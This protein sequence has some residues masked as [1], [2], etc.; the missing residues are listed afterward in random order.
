[1]MIYHIYNENNR[2]TVEAIT[3]QL[4]KTTKMIVVFGTDGIDDDSSRLKLIDTV[5]QVVADRS[6]YAGLFE[7]PTYLHVRMINSYELF[8]KRNELLSNKIEIEFDSNY[9][10]VLIT[11]ELKLAIDRYKNGDEIDTIRCNYVVYFLLD[12]KNKAV[13]VGYAKNLDKRLPAY[14]THNSNKLKVIK[15]IP[16]TKSREDYIKNHL[17]AFKIRGEWF[18]YDKYV[19]AFIDGLD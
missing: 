19:Q 2:A 12:T 15:T 6:Y 1:M 8:K 14:R 9:C 3:L 18:R 10:F 13:K 16:G 17:K 7:L 11:P 4:H 5:N